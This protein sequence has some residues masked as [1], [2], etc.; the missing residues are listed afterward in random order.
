[1]Q[2]LTVQVFRA[3]NALRMRMVQQSLW[4][5]PHNQQKSFTNIDYKMFTVSYFI[6]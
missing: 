5:P 6:L 4:E 1:M 3:R 2:L